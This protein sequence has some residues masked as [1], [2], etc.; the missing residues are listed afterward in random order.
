MAGMTAHPPTYHPEWFHWLVHGALI[1]EVL[2]VVWY[3]R[4]YTHTSAKFAT[5][6][7]FL[8]LA[9]SIFTVFLQ[10]FIQTTKFGCVF[11]CKCMRF[12]FVLRF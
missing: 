1:F 7:A 9:G 12:G 10:L 5:G 11:F 3:S 8:N 4:K 6:L 2:P